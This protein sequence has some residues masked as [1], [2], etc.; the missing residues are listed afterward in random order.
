[1]KKLFVLVLLVLAASVWVADKI[2][3]DPGYLL[4]SYQ[5]STVE[6]SLWFGLALLLV[7]VLTVHLGIWLITKLAASGSLVRRW[8][9]NRQY[10]KSAKKTTHGL[11]DYVEGNFKAAQK[12]LSQGAGKSETPLVNY[13]TAARA[14]A[15]NED[16]SA[17]ED[18]LR[19]AHE[20]APGAELAIGIAKAEI[21]IQQ[22]LP[23]QA[24]ASLLLLRKSHSRHRHVHK[25]LLQVYRD[26]R[27]WQALA[28]LMPTL[29]KLKVAPAAELDELEHKT[30]LTLFLQA[31]RD[32]SST[33]SPAERAALLRDVW[34]RVPM[35]SRRH[36]DITLDYVQFLNEL[37]QQEWAEPP[38]RDAIN[39]Q[40]SES[41]VVEYGL[42]NGKDPQHQLLTAE[43]WLKGH[44]HNANLLLALARLSLRNQLWG[45]ARE[46]LQS[47]V[48]L[49]PGVA[50]HAE[51]AR[52]LRHLGEDQSSHQY[53]LESF[54]LIEADLPAL[55]LPDKSKNLTQ[56]IASS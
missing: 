29:R 52:L 18:F 31:A 44:P 46:Y 50:A 8:S 45:K 56:A 16:E 13:L 27:D 43:G 51:L 28:D 14:A 11:I 25:L 9:H 41:L 42:V 24:L 38:L 32:N 19:R 20:V 17:T 1:M 30:I 37:D 36:E 23:E 26:L 6:T 22:G 21:R 4:I 53:V 2:M 7:A 48:K 54:R 33:L 10:R 40:W 47:C 3:Q 49:K 5:N 15:E 35:Q 12:K 34:A 55:P 39:H